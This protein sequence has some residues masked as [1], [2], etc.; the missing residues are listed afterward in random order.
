MPIKAGPGAPDVIQCSTIL[1][2]GIHKLSKVTQ[3]HSIH[4]DILLAEI[5]F[6]SRRLNGVARKARIIFFKGI[7]SRRVNGVAKEAKQR[8]TQPS[9]ERCR[10]GGEAVRRSKY[11]QRDEAERKKKEDLVYKS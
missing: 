5:H 6:K 2:S 9:C 1:V 3:D 4:R 7:H 8:S 10:Q 11:R